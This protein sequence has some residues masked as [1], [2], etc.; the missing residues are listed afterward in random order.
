[1]NEI[2]SAHLT[3]FFVGMVA[4]LFTWSIALNF[5]LTGSLEIVPPWLA[6]L[7]L[8][9]HGGT[10]EAGKV[11]WDSLIIQVGFYFFL[12]LPVWAFYFFS[13]FRRRAALTSILR[14]RPALKGGK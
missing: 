12:Q 6:V 8:Y 1:M 11:L 10:P 3:G 5:L 4:V 2:T 13:I 14:R 9:K 7:F